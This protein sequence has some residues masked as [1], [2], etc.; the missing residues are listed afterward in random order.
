[1]ALV[2][3]L[4]LAF[5]I[6]ILVLVVLNWQRS[7]KKPKSVRRGRT[8]STGPAGSAGSQGLAGAP[9]SSS[10]IIPYSSGAFTFNN[11]VF[12]ANLLSDDSKW[13]IGQC[14]ALSPADDLV[15]T[16][17]AARNSFAWTAPRAGTLSGFYMNLVIFLQG[18]SS[19]PTLSQNL[20]FT[21][22]VRVSPTTFASNDFAN[23]T[24][25]TTITI[26]AGTSSTDNELFFQSSDLVHTAAILAG[27]RVLV[28]ADVA[29]NGGNASDITSLLS[30]TGG[31]VFS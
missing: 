18:D 11:P 2:M 13:V 29:P 22:R 30:V 16:Q 20:V 21:F 4:L 17:D 23:T 10:T 28:E 8:G 5:A 1:M 25:T 14:G 27:Q 15:T 12:L 3:W 19:A 24:L 26:P 6:V 31:L 7:H 9:G